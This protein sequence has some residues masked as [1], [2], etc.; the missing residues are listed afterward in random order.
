MLDGK[1]LWGYLIALFILLLSYTSIGDFLIGKAVGL[2]DNYTSGPTVTASRLFAGPTQYPPKDF[3]AYGIFAFPARASDYDRSRHIMFCN[4]YISTLPHSSELSHLPQSK[5]MVTVW[6]IESNLIA[7]SLNRKPRSKVCDIAV[8]KYAL[9][10]S[11]QAIKDAEYSGNVKAVGRGPYL[12]AWS[13]AREKGKRNTPVLITDLSEISSPE[14]ANLF[15]SH[16]AKDIESNPSVWNNGFS[17][18]K[19]RVSLRL[20]AD[21]FGPKLMSA[22]QGNIYK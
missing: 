14:D 6:P 12:I 3:L 8:D 15:L 21:T 11:L 16:W 9:V 2:F 5:Q 20:W 22:F 17:I 1:K 19:I 18:E 7:D 13:P 10:S 4:A